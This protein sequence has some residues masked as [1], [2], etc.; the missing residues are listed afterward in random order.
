VWQKKRGKK[1]ET[2]KGHALG[3]RECERPMRENNQAVATVIR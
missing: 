1:K 2:G 3:R